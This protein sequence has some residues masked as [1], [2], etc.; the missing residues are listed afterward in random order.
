[1][2]FSKSGELDVVTRITGPHHHYLALQLDPDG[3]PSFV[4]VECIWPEGLI[5]SV[6]PT[7]A[8]EIRLEVS[9]GIDAANKRL[10]TRFR[11]IRIR[12]GASDP[13]VKDVYRSMAERLVEHV[14]GLQGQIAAASLRSAVNLR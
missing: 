12:I 6:E 2:R 3:D 11:V 10:A 4:D 8:A 7:R 9:L 14:R 13:P 5:G 1:M